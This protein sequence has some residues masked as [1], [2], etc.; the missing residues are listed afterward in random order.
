[1]AVR[2]KLRSGRPEA[3]ANLQITLTPASHRSKNRSANFN[4][5]YPDGAAIIFVERA[6]SAF[7]VAI[8]PL[9]FANVHFR[10]RARS[11]DTVPFVRDDKAGV[12]S[13][14]FPCRTSVRREFLRIDP[15]VDHWPA[16]CAACADLCH[17]RAAPKL[18]IFTCN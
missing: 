6:T 9:N 5:N 10:S 12:S 3:A 18:A 7:A 4:R 16:R 13:R 17:G 2:P 14:V 15:I 8:V 1:M 11:R